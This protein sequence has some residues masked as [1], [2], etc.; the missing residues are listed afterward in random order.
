M[1]PTGIICAVLDCDADSIEQWN[2][3]Y[4]LEHVPPNVSMQ[5]VMLGRRYV[6][7]PELHELRTADAASGFGNRHGTFVTIYTLCEPP[8]ET[9]GRMSTLREKLY[10]ENRMNFPPEKKV[11][12]DG[13][14]LVLVSGVS[15]KELALP[16][17]DI[18]FLGH[19]AVILVQR[20]ASDAVAEWYRTEW[21]SK[22]VEVDG[23][24]GVMSLRYEGK[25]GE[26]LD[27]VFMEGDAVALTKAVRAAAPHHGDATIV[28]DAPFLLI[29]PLRYPWADAI[30]ASS[31]PQTVND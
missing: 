27:V 26:E 31:L 23:V 9:V 21:S 12:R 6:S 19:T 4:D 13:G 5:G 10:A 18:P 28:A 3:W 17:E 16:V 30:R 29:D 24:H 2:R 22:V 14:A 25:T 1:Q 8:L 15:S 7:P 20:R 11:V